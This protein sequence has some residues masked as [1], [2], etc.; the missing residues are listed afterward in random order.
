VSF[1]VTI[2][3]SGSALPTSRRNPTS[4]FVLCSNRN[5]L[6]DCGE[7]TQ[8]QM[9]K[10]GVKFQKI[11]IVLISHLHG[12]H[13][14]GLVGLLSTMHLL[15]RTKSL[16][17]YGPIGLDLI[18]RSQLEA[19]GNRLNYTIDV[20]EL[21]AGYDGELFQDEKIEISTF[22]LNHRV[23]T[24]GFVIIEKQ[25]EAKLL[26]KKALRDNVKIE[27]YHRL[28]KGEDIVEDG[29]CIKAEEYTKKGPP[30]KKYAFCSDTKYSESII[31]FIQNVDLLYHEAT[32]TEKF[33][34]RA[35]STYHSTAVQAATIAKLASVS[36]LIMG[37]LSARYEN[38]EVHAQEALEVFSNSSVVEDGDVFS[39]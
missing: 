12:D 14:F 1:T 20:Q 8:M 2:L 6:I 4:Q 38:G 7:G 36:K 18:L 35:K 33:I 9:R 30:A 5:I 23:D 39:V 37:H 26:Q 34:D 27:Y 21:T 17:V 28:K 32:F 16:K 31:P 19:D 24:F 13:Y 11:D 10:F 25:K 3:G 15:G 29:V 22:P